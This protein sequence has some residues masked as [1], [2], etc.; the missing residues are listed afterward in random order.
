MTSNKKSVVNPRGVFSL[1]LFQGYAGQVK[2]L[3][4]NSACKVPS[5]SMEVTMGSFTLTEV[6]VSVLLLLIV[7][8]ALLS[9]FVSAKRSD[10]LAQAHLVAQQ[11]GRSE[12]ERLWTNTY[13]N[14]VSVTN[15]ALSNTTLASLQG[16]I[17]Y[18]VTTSSYYKD[19]AITVEWIAPGSSRRQ[20]VTNY[21]TICDTN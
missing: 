10:G 18:G 5:R 15:L 13:S 8:G 2:R 6:M 11:I 4:K 19:I 1:R 16:R 20:A 9:A 12:A 17:S 21:I 7:M 3:C 14:I